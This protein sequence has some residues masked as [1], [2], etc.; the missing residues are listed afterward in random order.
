M[1][2]DKNNLVNIAIQELVGSGTDRA[3]RDLNIHW[4]YIWICPRP[5][6][7]YHMTYYCKKCTNMAF[8]ALH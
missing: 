6:T 5:L 7:L 3:W 1:A 2:L 4:Q 8:V